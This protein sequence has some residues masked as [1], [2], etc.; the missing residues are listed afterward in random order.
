MAISRS[1]RYFAKVLSDGSFFECKFTRITDHSYATKYQDAYEDEI[2]DVNIRYWLDEVPVE[3]L[4][5]LPDEVQ[6]NIEDWMNEAKASSHT[7]FWY[8]EEY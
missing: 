6:E 8:S 5:E 7:D 1:N 2:D 4:D 3:T